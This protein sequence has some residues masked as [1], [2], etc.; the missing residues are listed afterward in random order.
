MENKAMN[1]WVNVHLLYEMR[2][3]YAVKTVLKYMIIIM[4][5]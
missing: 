1:T 4:T 3:Y 2:M 5:W